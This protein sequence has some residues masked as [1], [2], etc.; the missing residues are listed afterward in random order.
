MNKKVLFVD[1]DTR[2][3]SAFQRRL[4]RNFD[5]QIA[6]SA[7]DA[8]EILSKDGPFAV[9]IS[10]QQMPGMKGIEFLKEVMTRDPMT[11]RIML[12]G[13][14]DRETA[15]ASVNDSAVYRYLNKPCPIE[16]IAETIDEAIREYGT[17]AAEKKLLEETLAGSVKVLVDV[18][19]ANEPE[20]FNA[21]ANLR[22]NGQRFA[23][24]LKLR[25]TWTLD[26]A[27]ML[28]PIGQVML[29]PQLRAKLALGK[30]LNDV[31][32]DLARRAPEVARNLL[33]NIPRLKDVA[34][35]IYYMDKGYDGSGFPDDRVAGDEIPLN[36]RILCLLKHLTGAEHQGLPDADAFEALDAKAHLFDRDLLAQMRTC[37][38][39]PAASEETQIVKRSLKI[40]ELL[41]GDKAVN[42]VKT[43]SGELVLARGNE[44]SDA[45]IERIRQFHKMRPLAEPVEI[46]REITVPVDGD[47]DAA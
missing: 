20:A 4:R 45:V 38:L 17:A 14:A 26:M 5:F 31:E 29:P 47:K 16:V 2:I 24:F 11:V 41:P 12:T 8:L 32:Q 40:A 21:V 10:D 22:K 35:S 37:F 6:S 25:K 19:A 15:V 36:A 13:N 30:P 28:S 46:T 9:V 39:N 18:L 44:F 3:L 23:R 7:Q 33:L 27:I 1:D 34:D 42:D 43:Q